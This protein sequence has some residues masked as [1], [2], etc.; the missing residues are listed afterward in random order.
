MNFIRE[1]GI[2]KFVELQRKRI[3]LLEAMINDFDDGRSKSFYCKRAA[4]LDVSRLRNSIDMAYRQIEQKQINPNDAK[5]RAK[6]LKTILQ[7]R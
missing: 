1:H 7:E 2:G 5:K 3:D 6:M 4:L